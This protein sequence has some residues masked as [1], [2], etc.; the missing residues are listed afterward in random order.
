MAE[1]GTR[2]A[3]SI[4][5]RCCIQ[6]GSRNLDTSFPDYDFICE[7]CGLVVKDISEID[8][9]QQRRLRA[10]TEADLEQNLQEWSDYSTV[11]NSTESR[12]VRAIEILE[13]VA[14][15]LRLSVE[16]RQETA[17]VYGEA[18]KA[19]A[20][21]GRATELLVACSIVIASREKQVPRPIV[22]VAR[23]VGVDEGKL[24]RIVRAVQPEVKG[25]QITCPP[26]DYIGYLSRELALDGSVQ[27]SAEEIIHAANEDGLTT[28]KSPA[29]VAGAAL[30]G[31]AEGSV[32]QREVAEVAGVSKE[33][34]RSRLKELRSGGMLDG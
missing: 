34:I 6:C 29:G 13:E 27:S 9:V 11:T 28:G 1:T 8:A 12:I 17:E 20:T 24:R 14:D 16:L 3:E 2:K 5:K 19:G 7:S 30:Y 21:D 33:T 25:K 10:T 26:E 15:S 22:R 4:K 23:A 18:A 32:S 31:A